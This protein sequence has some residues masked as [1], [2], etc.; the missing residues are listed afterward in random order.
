MFSYGFDR[1]ILYGILIGLVIFDLLSMS[2]ADWLSILLTLPAVVIAI[3]IHE[4]SHAKAAD[5]LGDRTPR[6]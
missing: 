3:T 1:R 2:R 4:F 6:A 5:V